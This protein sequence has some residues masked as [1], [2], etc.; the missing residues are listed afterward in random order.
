MP[1]PAEIPCSSTDP[2]E[3]FTTTPPAPA[4]EQ[5]KIRFFEVVGAYR[6]TAPERAL[7]RIL[8][9]LAVPR[10][11]TAAFRATAIAVSG[12]PVSPSTVVCVAWVIYSLANTA[13]LTRVPH[14]EIAHHARLDEKTARSAIALLEYWRVIRR[15]R[16][17]RR[18][19]EI[20]TMNLGGLSWEMVRHRLRAARRNDSTKSEPRLFPEPLPEPP[21]PGI[22]PGLK[23]PSPGTMPGPRAVR[24]EGL[25]T[26]TTA[27]SRG[28]PEPTEAQIAFA[29]D[30]G[31]D[32]SGKDLVELGAAIETARLERQAN[33][34]AAMPPNTNGRR[35]LSDIKQRRLAEAQRAEPRSTPRN[36]TTE[37]TPERAAERR[38]EGLSVA[39]ALG[40][41]PDPANAEYLIGSGGRRIWIGAEPA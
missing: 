19:A 35:R 2:G 41:R 18:T 32:P 9:D 27:R 22:V 40:F 21:S 28:R 33:R 31:I 8:L 30:L 6:G 3:Q 24:T 1:T 36:R 16:P 13:G 29:Q 11:A 4:P 12:R 37:Q 34:A 20:I 23:S 26:T 10:I 14:H 15:H 25:Y 17:K 5:L 39:A 7:W 38:R